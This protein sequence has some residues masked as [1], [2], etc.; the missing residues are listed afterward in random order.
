MHS[1]PVRSEASRRRAEGQFK[2]KKNADAQTGHAGDSL[3]QAEAEKTVRLRALRLAKEV[4]DREA[5]AREAA[6]ALARKAEPRRRV[7]G[8]RVSDAVEPK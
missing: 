4:V 2:S 6:A 1:Q 5:A 7:S 3:R 8:R